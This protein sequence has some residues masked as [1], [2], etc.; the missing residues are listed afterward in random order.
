M[1]GAW[2]PDLN[3]ADEKMACE[4]FHK[5]YGQ[6]RTAQIIKCK[7]SQVLRAWKKNGLHRGMD[8]AKAFFTGTLAPTH[9]CYKTTKGPLTDIK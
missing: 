9:A 6:G 7:Y 3:E 5:G 2:T 4:L 8:E 1:G